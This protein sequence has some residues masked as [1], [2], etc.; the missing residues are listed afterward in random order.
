M[1]H[2][3]IKRR[4]INIQFFLFSFEKFIWHIENV[5]NDFNLINQNIDKFYDS[6]NKMRIITNQSALIK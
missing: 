1:T 3:R 4:L 2:Y 6:N 5:E